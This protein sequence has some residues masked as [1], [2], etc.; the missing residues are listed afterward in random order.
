LADEIEMSSLSQR[1][2][3]AEVWRRTRRNPGLK[4]ISVLIALGLWMFV[5]AGQRGAVE[6][7]QVPIS[8][9]SLPTGLVIINRPTDFVKIEVAGPRT[10]LSLLDPERLTLKLDLTGVPTGRSDFKINSAM[11]NVPRQ[12]SVTRITPAEVQLDID[13]VVSRQIPVHLVLAGKVAHG[14]QVNSVQLT[15]SAIFV[16]GPSRYV[17][18]LT[19]ADTDPLDIKGAS[20]DLQRIVGLTSPNHDVHLSAEKV[21]AAVDIGEIIANRE[22]KGVAVQ[23]RDTDHKYRLDPAKATITLRGP[24]LKLSSLDPTG[25]VYVDAKD[26]TPGSHDM[27]VQV[28]LP[29]GMELVKQE[30]E[31]VRI[32][33]YREKRPATTD[34]KT[35]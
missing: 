21:T 15:P 12:T 7:L 26:G 25:I 11:F 1:F 17:M 33:I 3:L 8:Y 18:P 31:K 29:D 20:A 14:Y 27:A 34:G 9:R 22:F 4:I 28:D 6:A 2:R 16:S 10:L 35:S 24:V 19:E 32:R 23:V 5:N 13:R 30:P